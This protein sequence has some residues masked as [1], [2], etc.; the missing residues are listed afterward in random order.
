MSTFYGMGDRAMGRE[1]G[2]SGNWGRNRPDHSSTR[3]FSS[4]RVTRTRSIRVYVRRKWGSHGHLAVG[5][6][7]IGHY[8]QP[9]TGVLMR[10]LLTSFFRCLVALALLVPATLMTTSPAAAEIGR[11]SCRERV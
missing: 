2:R 4:C 9:I 6:D 1:I 7:S 5:C 8:A 11:A 3:G 10:P